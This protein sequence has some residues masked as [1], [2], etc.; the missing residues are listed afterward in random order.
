MLWWKHCRHLSG[1]QVPTQGL[2]ELSVRLG[3]DASAGERALRLVRSRHRTLSFRFDRPAA[4][5]AVLPTRDGKVYGFRVLQAVYE[6]RE[7]G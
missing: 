1:P 5:R 7:N 4:W 2:S 3:D 6:A